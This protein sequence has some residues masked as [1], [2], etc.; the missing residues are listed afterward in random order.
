MKK[1]PE[2]ALKELHTTE[3]KEQK[4]DKEEKKPKKKRGM[5]G[6]FRK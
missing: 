6:F 4:P 1:M 5:M 3:N 2:D